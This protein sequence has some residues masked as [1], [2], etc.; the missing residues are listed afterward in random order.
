MSIPR[1]LQLWIPLFAGLLVTAPSVATPPIKNNAAAAFKKHLPY[2]QYQPLGKTAIGILA[3]DAN[4]IINLEGRSGPPDHM[5]FSQ[6]GLSYRWVYV[7][8]QGNARITNL[9]VPVDKGQ[10]KVLYPALD[11]ASPNTVKRFGAGAFNLVQVEVND[12]QGSPVNDS[13][14]ATNIKVL[15]GSEAYPLK[16]AEVLER[17]RKD[18][19]KSQTKR[20]ADI[21]K[22]MSGLQKTALGNRKP[23]GKR[24]QKDRMYVTWMTNNDTLEVRFLSEISNGYY[25]YVEGGA[26]IRPFPLPVPPNKNGKFPPRPLPPKAVPNA[27]PKPGNVAPVQ[28]KPGP[29]V[30][31]ARPQPGGIAPPPRFKVKVGTTFG[32]TLG[33]VYTV[34]KAGKITASNPIE[35]QPFQQVIAPPPAVGFPVDPP[36]LPVL[37]RPKQ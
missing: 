32:V 17:L 7:E 8:V 24:Q 37:P 33:N 11:M 20:N 22:A 28:A 14:V 16:V 19:A 31:Q 23:N 30:P 35:I 2:R 10:T 1:S 5:G 6:D 29:V 3:G 36:A 21:D 4:S 13:F 25:Y 26:P 12:G 27:L 18:Y 15:D 34:S 9:K